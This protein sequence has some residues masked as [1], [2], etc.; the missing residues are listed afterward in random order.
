MTL[1]LRSLVMCTFGRLYLA[2]ASERIPPMSIEFRV[3][4]T[5]NIGSEIEVKIWHLGRYG[6]EVLRG[7]EKDAKA[8]DREG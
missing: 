3:N 1:C 8:F 2:Y 4:D 7:R 5:S 6:I